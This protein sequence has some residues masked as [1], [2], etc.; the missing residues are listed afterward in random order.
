LRVCV[1]S[2]GF[3]NGLLKGSLP[4]RYGNAGIGFLWQTANPSEGVLVSDKFQQAA[5]KLKQ[6]QKKALSV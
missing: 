5:K 1:I 2:H 4:Q 6:Q 3:S